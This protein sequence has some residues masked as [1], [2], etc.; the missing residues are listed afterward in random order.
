MSITTF[1]Y[2]CHGGDNHVWW[3][4]PWRQ[5]CSSGPQWSWT[6]VWLRS[7]AWPTDSRNKVDPMSFVMLV[8]L[9]CFV[10][11]APVL[12][13]TSWI[14]PMLLF[15]SVPLSIFVQDGR[16]CSWSALPLVLCC[17]AAQNVLNVVVG[18]ILF[19]ENIS[20]NHVVGFSLQLVG[21]FLWHVGALGEGRL[22]PQQGCWG[23]HSGHSAQQP[24]VPTLRAFQHST[25]CLSL[26]PPCGQLP[27]S[28]D[29]HRQV[30]LGT[31]WSRARLL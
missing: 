6:L 15:W 5:S 22:Q 14:H 8:M 11:T 29:P 30:L 2:R 24:L 23:R 31:T 7:M 9:F 27:V 19:S 16:T 13:L 25:P 3:S 17:P 4:L 21:I 28:P 18:A 26:T 20:R 12:L 10:L 1:E